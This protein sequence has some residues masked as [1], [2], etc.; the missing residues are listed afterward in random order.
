MPVIPVLKAEAGGSGV[1]D[2]PGLYNVRPCLKERK[3]N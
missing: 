3:K 2:Q 1:Q